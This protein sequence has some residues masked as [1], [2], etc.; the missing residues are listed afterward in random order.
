[1]PR[2]SGVRRCSR[3]NKKHAR[4]F[5]V[6]ELETRRL[7]SAVAVAVTSPAESAVS[8]TVTVALGQPITV[9]ATLI[10]H[11]DGTPIKPDITGTITFEF[12]NVPSVNVTVPVAVLTG[13]SFADAGSTASAVLPTNLL[14]PGDTDESIEG[15]YNGNNVYL[16]SS[17][18]DNN[19]FVEFTSAPQ[20]L[21]FIQNPSNSAADDKI[22]PAVTVAVEDSSGNILTSAS[23]TVS[24]AIASGTG[25]L[26]GTISASAIDGIATF[27]NLSIDTS[28]SYTLTA[29]DSSAAAATSSLFTITAGKLVFIK[30]PTA[31][32]AGEPIKPAITVALEDGTGK[33][34]SQDSSTVVTLGPIGL[35]AGSPITGD[36]ATLSDGVATFSDLTL[37]KPGFYQLQATDGG[38]TQ[39]TSAK[40]KIAGDKLEFLKQP[41]NNDVNTPVPLTVELV[42][43][44]GKRVTD[45]TMTIVLSLTAVSG[46]I[47]ADLSGTTTLAFV[48]GLATFTATAGPLINAPGKYTLTATEED[49]STG[50]L[51][52]TNTTT[53]ITS[54]AFAIGGQQLVFLKKPGVTDVNSPLAF[55][56]A[57]EDKQHQVD[58][59]LDTGTVQ[60]TLTPISGGAG[61]A[62]S[63]YT[64]IG[65]IGGVDTF[66]SSS[67]PAVDTPGIYTLTAVE[68][69]ASG[70]PVATTAAATFAPLKILGDHLVFLKSPSTVSIRQDLSFSIAIEDSLGKIDTS[71]NSTLVRIALPAG[72]SGLSGDFQADLTNGV[73]TWGNINPITGAGLGLDIPSAGTYHL[74]ASVGGPEVTPANSGNFKVMPYHLVFTQQPKNINYGD[75]STFSVVEKDYQGEINTSDRTTE[76]TINGNTPVTLSGG[77]YSFSGQLRSNALADML[78][79]PGTYK[80]T[81]AQQPTAYGVTLDIKAASEQFKIGGFHLVFIHQPMSSTAGAIVGFTVE[82]MDDKD[83]V[84]SSE[85]PGVSTDGVSIAVVPVDGSPTPQTSGATQ[86]DFESGYAAFGGQGEFSI[87]TPGTY[88]LVA[89]E[90]NSAFGLVTPIGTDITQSATSEK[91][92]VT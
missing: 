90:I 4:L 60:L 62:L 12:V 10:F 29:T 87:L 76:I 51:A 34:I 91:F 64:N 37:T 50:A 36:T 26:S 79:R 59:S 17:S 82:I 88:E 11:D 85:S 18:T 32:N 38:D 35:T 45:V 53:A 5:H 58:T 6:E 39:A 14:P 2:V 33:I 89:T 30:A 68:L 56:V 77:L 24:V 63:S 23:D 42:D 25:T 9:N 15:I 80:L 81:A 46:G 55:V 52:P 21:A 65:F 70:N 44:S 27:S 31:G 72:A 92:K 83:Q 1:M 61:A 28:G 78:Y 49:Y 22:A 3:I 16:S 47:N 8:D 19:L 57:V 43:T 67:A 13:G 20:R 40:F 71:D 69:D 41:A 54:K 84:V 75:S 86:E 73:G 66:R 74:T 7:L 48:A